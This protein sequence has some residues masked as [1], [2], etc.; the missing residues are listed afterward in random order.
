MNILRV[1]LFVAEPEYDRSQCNDKCD[2]IVEYHG[3]Y[4]G[5]FFKDSFQVSV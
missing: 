5:K 4:G 1:K 3:D 2:G